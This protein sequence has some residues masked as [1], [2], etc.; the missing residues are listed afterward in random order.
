M[1][2]EI[3]MGSALIFSSGLALI[4]LALFILIFWKAIKRLF[5]NSVTGI[6]ALLILH[7]AFGV[8]IPLTATTLI[9]TALFGTAGVGTML[10]LKIGGLF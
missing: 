7:Y 5:I 9:I 2:N 3:L 10:I 4:L 1:A 8:D 6:I